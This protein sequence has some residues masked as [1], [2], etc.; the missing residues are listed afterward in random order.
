MSQCLILGSIK[1]NGDVL[2]LAP[3]NGSELGDKIA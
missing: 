1:S 3:E 2:L